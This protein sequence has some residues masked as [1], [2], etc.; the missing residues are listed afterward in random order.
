MIKQITDYLNAHGGAAAFHEMQTLKGKDITLSTFDENYKKTDSIVNV[1]IES[2]YPYK[3][4][5]ISLDEV[6]EETLKE[7]ITLIESHENTRN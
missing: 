5:Y 7:I 3:I 2:F 4:N 6:K 1:A